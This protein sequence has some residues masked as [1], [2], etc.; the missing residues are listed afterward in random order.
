MSL[1]DGQPLTFSV[2]TCTWNSEPYLEDSIQSVL[3]QDYPY[4]E[5]VFVDGGSTDGTLKRIRG[6]DHPH[7]L[8]ENVSGGISRAMNTGIAVANGE[9]IAHLHSDDYYLRSDTLS[10]V[11]RHFQSS[12]R[13]WLFGRIVRD[14]EGTLHGEGFECP[15]YTYAR[16]L[17]R[18]FIPHPATFVKRDLL[19]SVGG[20]D[21]S[22]KYAMDYD[23]WLRLGKV[24]EP[25]QMEEELAVFREHSRSLSSTNRLPALREDLLVRLGYVGGNPLTRTVHRSRYVV[26]RHRLKRV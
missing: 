8:L 5:L 16:L 19:A 4:V 9:V 20:F 13:R 23:L 17:R 14:V 3:G 1:G 6:L 26:R 25:I 21:T 18:N 11:A 24:D 10:T 7:R 2:I 12:E 22:L 15:A